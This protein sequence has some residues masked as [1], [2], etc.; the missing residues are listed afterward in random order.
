MEIWINCTGFPPLRLV[1]E[2]IVLGRSRSCDFH[3]PHESVSRKHAWIGFREGRAVVENQS[4]QA[5]LL[6]GEPVEGTAPIQVGDELKLGPYIVRLADGPDQFWDPEGEA[7]TS[8]SHEELLAEVA[9]KRLED[10]AAERARLEQEIKEG[11][12]ELESEV[13]RGLHTHRELTAA[14]RELERLKEK[15][16]RLSEE[17]VDAPTVRHAKPLG[18][19]PL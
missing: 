19:R 9:K 13:W 12:R 5:L 4:S 15:L 3:L 17:A 6:N 11:R 14:T 7:T 18:R 10:A 1:D 16:A 8:L 2:P